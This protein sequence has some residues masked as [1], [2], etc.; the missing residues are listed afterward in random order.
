MPKEGPKPV[1]T[2]VYQLSLSTDCDKFVYVACKNLAFY[3]EVSRWHILHSKPYFR[4][5]NVILIS[6]LRI[7]GV[8]HDGTL[9]EIVRSKLHRL[10]RQEHD[11]LGQRWQVDL[12]LHHLNADV[13]MREVFED[14]FCDSR[15]A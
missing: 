5:E 9:D 10:Q 3:Y 4:V 12:R 15:V 6:P 7:D 8:G 13:D 14:R 2:Q 1:I 11:F